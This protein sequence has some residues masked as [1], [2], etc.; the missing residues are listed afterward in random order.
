MEMASA[1]DAPHM[2][3]TEQALFE[4]V[5]KQ[6]RRFLEFGLGGSTLVAVRSKVGTIVS[7][8]SDPTWVAAVRTHVEVAPRIADGTMSVLHA[9]IGP[10]R[11]WGNP[12]DRQEMQK[13]PRY[14]IAAWSEWV[15]RRQFPDLVLVDGRFRIACC[16][17]VLLAAARLS[18]STDAL[19]S[20]LLHDFT[21]E[22]PQYRQLL[23]LFDIHHQA[24]SL[25][26]LKIRA[27]AS[28]A[29]ALTRLLVCQFDYG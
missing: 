18:P 21:D 15:R 19:P 14:L 12:V 13:W 27:S 23:Q 28:V 8:D 17:S 24:E 22:R 16:L 6:S 20:V 5:V 10:V 25:C 4:T 3:A 26:H 1:L 29:D 2:S 11:E 7:V 9:D